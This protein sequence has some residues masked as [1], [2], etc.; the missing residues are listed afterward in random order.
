MTDSL[1]GMDKVS[2]IVP[3]YGVER[4]LSECVDS[5]ID[6]TYCN[7][8]IILVDDGSLDCCGKICDEYAEKDKRIVVIHKPNGGV[9]SARNAGLAVATGEW[10]MYVDGDD[11]VNHE[12]VGK[13]VAKAYAENAD[14]VVADFYFAF[15]CQINERYGSYSWNKQGMDGLAEYIST[16]WTVL[17]GSIHRR[18]LY[19]S[20]GFRC[21]EKITYCEDFHLM[22]RLCFEAKQIAKVKEALY[23]YRQQESSVMHNLDK[24]SEHDEQW[25]YSD[26]I[27]FFK[28]RGVYERFKR[29]MAWRSL[30]AAQ[31]MVLDTAFFD[32][33][34]DYNPDK[35]P[36]IWSCPFIGLKLKLLMWL[37][38]HRLTFFARVLVNIRK[39][40]R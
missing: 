11:Y 32:D 22:V 16:V 33:F 27:R 15:P 35:G 23:Y 28:E 25:V 9:C 1:T 4:Y 14:I 39:V 3:V 29:Q 24:K 37:M 13:L 19:E 21:P 7:I 40:V 30:K 36:Y 5:L 17:W 31:E 12:L 26:I 18:R 2:I 38:T 8:E 10:I 34:R 6:Q 20:T